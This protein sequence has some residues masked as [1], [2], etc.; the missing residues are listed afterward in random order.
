MDDVTFSIPIVLQI[1][2]LFGIMAFAVTGALKAIEYKMDIVGVIMLASSTGL[3]GG[4]I[5]DV[6]L[7]RIPPKVLV[8]PFYLLVAVSTG[9][10]VFFLYRFF[11]ENFNLFL[12]FDAIGL[13]V[14]SIIGASVAYEITGL[15][16]IAMVF[17]GIFT[18]IG[19]GIFRDIIVK[20]IPLVFLK[21]LYASASFLGITIF[22]IMLFFEINYYFSMMIC[23]VIIT[24][25]RLLSMK[26]NW[27]LP[28]LHTDEKNVD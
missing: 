3:A 5:R 23:I 7:N 20:E 6:I 21:E 16:F 24:V 22:Y 4:L 14:F 28:R 25:F 12:K 15:N 26:F 2:D 8:D 18:A 9:L 19:G 11:K 17:A 10:I 27:N 1:L 13:G